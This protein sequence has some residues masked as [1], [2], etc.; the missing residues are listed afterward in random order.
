VSSVIAD[1]ERATGKPVV[2]SN[3]AL[4]WFCLKTLGI[5]IRPTGYGALM[6]T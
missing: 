3:S 5:E 2:T 6:A 1:I 4:L